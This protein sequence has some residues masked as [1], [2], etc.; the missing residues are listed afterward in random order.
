MSA[1]ELIT[2]L[3]DGSSWVNKVTYEPDTGRQEI[4][5]IKGANINHQIP[6]VIFM[7]FALAMF[8]FKDQ[9]GFSSVGAAVSHFIKTHTEY[10]IKTLDTWADGLVDDLNMAQR[11][12]LVASLLS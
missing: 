7:Q 1:V 3:V 12:A 6:L 10:N 8:D 2:V 9:D 5:T 4:V 11:D